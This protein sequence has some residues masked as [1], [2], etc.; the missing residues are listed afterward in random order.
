MTTFLEITISLDGDVAAPCSS[1][2][3][4]PD[5]PAH[6]R[7][8]RRCARPRGD[9]DVCVMGAGELAR[10]ALAAGLVDE[11][12]LHVAPFAMGAGTRL[13]G[14][15]RLELEPGPVVESPAA[16]HISYRVVR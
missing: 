5:R 14:E 2:Q 8:R 10:R 15:Q 7:S 4:R 11:L 6:V 12:R 9:R 1:A 3:A 13:F 16:T